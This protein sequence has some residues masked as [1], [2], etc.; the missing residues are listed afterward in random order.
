[1]PYLNI[2]TTYAKWSEQ[3]RDA[4]VPCPWCMIEHTCP[5]NISWLLMDGEN[6][7][8]L[9]PRAWEQ[10][11]TPTNRTPG[12]NDDIRSDGMYYG[13]YR[14]TTLCGLKIVGRPMDIDLLINRTDACAIC[15]AKRW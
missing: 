13:I 5:S 8:H 9:V 10:D 3:D 4:G 14:D 12:T 2:P 7:Y 15:W 6:F 1:M 11:T